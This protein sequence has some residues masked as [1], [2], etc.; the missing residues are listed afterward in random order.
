MKN[1]PDWAKEVIASY[2]SGASECF[3][4][5]G[6]VADQM[7]INSSQT[8]NGERKLGSL[9]DFVMEG[10]LPRFDVIIT[11]DMGAGLR[12]ERGS[13]IFQEWPT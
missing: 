1:L 4:L 5:H 6:N 8:M 3:L 10:L 12:V 13:D 2:E 7:M 9:T 11:F